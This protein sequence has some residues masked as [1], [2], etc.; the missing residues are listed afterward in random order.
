[1]ENQVSFVR[2]G[3]YYNGGWA[4]CARSMALNNVVQMVGNGGR[5]LRIT[6]IRSI[7][8]IK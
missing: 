1:M 2:G 7:W 3:G 6:G 8:R 5:A 4:D